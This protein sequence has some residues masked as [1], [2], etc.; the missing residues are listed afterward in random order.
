MRDRIH[1]LL[2][3]LR[4]FAIPVV[5]ETIP[6]LDA[7]LGHLCL[8]G[9]H[10]PPAKG[11]ACFLIGDGKTGIVEKPDQQTVGRTL[12]VD[13]DTITVEDDELRS[14]AVHCVPVDPKPPEPRA[15]SPANARSSIRA[16]TT[17]AMTA[18]AIRVPRVTA[19]SSS[20]KLA[21]ST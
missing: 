15:V 2:E 1:A 5:D 14:R 11:F 4:Q 6:E 9:R 10:R 12:R 7:G 19:K 3:E 18:W 8:D 20:P 16:C 13:E 17:G 21:S